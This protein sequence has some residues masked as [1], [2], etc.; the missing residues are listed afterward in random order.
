M[1]IGVPKE[2]M[3][4]ERRVAATPETVKLLIE[5]GSEVIVQTGAGI[6]AGFSDAQYS[7]QGAALE[8]DARRI[9]DKA[10]I[11]LKVKEPQMNR[12]LGLHEVDLMHAGQV[13]ISFI[14]PASPSNHEMVRN[15]AKKGII[16][17]TLDGLPR[18]PRAECM[19]PLITMSKCGG[20]KGM[21]MAMDAMPR[22][23]PKT[24]T[25]VGTTPPANV[26]VVGVG[27]GGLAALTT[28]KALGANLFAA[29]VH[30]KA[31]ETARVLGAEIVALGVPTD[32]AVQ[33]GS[34]QTLSA[35]WAEKGQSAIARILPEM[36]IVFLGALVPSKLAPVL[37]TE[38]MVRL[39]K[40]GSVIV[41]L[42]IDQG[43]NCALSPQGGSE[44]RYGV[45]LFGVKNIPGM[46]PE[47]ASFMFAQ[48][49]YNL[50]AYLSR[51]GAFALDPEDEIV[52]GILTTFGG[53]VVHQGAK[54]AMNMV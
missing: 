40:P 6:G 26:L 52:Q 51:G 10:E 20:Y 42:S 4:G 1:I 8:P 17:L 43:G 53:E 45:T 48:N 29:D 25:A 35:E 46:L 44:V 2:V 33:A 5:G 24:V 49:V 11:I 9:F 18:I 50:V 32:V 15:M 39:M 28:A 22:F 47:S 21:L 27:V 3:P 30:P 37:I 16:G 38:E 36:D 14:H 41:D 7:A 31:V 19:D 34:A 13:L 54:E 12:E 23:V